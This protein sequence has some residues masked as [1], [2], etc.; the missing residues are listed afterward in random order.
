MHYCNLNKIFG[1]DHLKIQNST[2]L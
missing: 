1:V 2:V